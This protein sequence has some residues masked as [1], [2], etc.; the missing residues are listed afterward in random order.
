MSKIKKH[1]VIVILLLIIGIGGLFLFDMDSEECSWSKYNVYTNI[2]GGVRFFGN[3][4][5]PIVGTYDSKEKC[6]FL[7]I[8]CY[9]TEPYTR[10][11][12]GE[13][14]FKLKTG[15]LC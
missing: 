14:C 10:F 9:E 8:S 4:Y 3:C 2:S 13:V 15:E 1:L 6:G 7:G 12:K 5:V 11:Y